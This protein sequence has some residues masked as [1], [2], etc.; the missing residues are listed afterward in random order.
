MRII[1]AGSRD[2]TDY[3]FLRDKL[4]ATEC[5]VAPLPSVNSSID[6]FFAE[7]PVNQAQTC[8]FP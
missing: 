7:I 4:G 8:V 1:V 2:F 3:N 5:S 6:K